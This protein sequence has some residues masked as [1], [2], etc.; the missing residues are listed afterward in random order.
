VAY[1]AYKAEQA[2][3][4]ECRSY[5]TELAALVKDFYSLR[6]KR[7]A[8]AQVTF[9]GSLQLKVLLPSSDDDQRAMDAI[10]AKT[11]QLS[12][13]YARRCGETRSDA[14]RAENFNRLRLE[15]DPQVD[16]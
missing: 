6:A 13:S 14:W 9:N 16:E 12:S 10:S 3:E 11:K 4:V 5:E 1:S 7:K 8:S 15:G 2:K